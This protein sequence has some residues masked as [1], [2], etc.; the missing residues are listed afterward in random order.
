MTWLHPRLQRQLASAGAYTDVLNA[1]L[2][3]VSATYEDTDRVLHRVAQS[4]PTLMAGKSELGHSSGGQRSAE[5]EYRSLFENAVCGIYRDEL[6]GTPVRCN[7][8]LASL[9]GYDTEAEYISA[10]RGAH[11]AWYVE[12]GKSEHFKY[13]MLNEG[14]VRDMVSEVYRHKTREK[15]WITE[16]AWYVRDLEG[17]P[18]FIEGTIQD[19]TER[20]T[21]MA[22]VE[23]QANIDTLT[24]VASRFKF[25]NALRQETIANGEGC[26]LFSIDLD[27]FKEV[28][29]TLGHAAGDVVLKIT[30]ERLQMIADGAGLVARLGGDEFA[31]L[32]HGAFNT[33]DLEAF[34]GNII[35]VMR[36]P[37][38]VGGQN[39]I[40]GASVGIASFPT[41]ADD[42]EEL[43]ANADM[44]L[45]RA[46]MAGR[47]G[48]CIFD[49]ELRVTSQNNKE[50][51]SQLRAA[52]AEDEL[53]LHYQPIVLSCHYAY[54][55]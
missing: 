55:A 17:N 4:L 9:N 6:D 36:E 54:H 22:I 38:Q 27:R 43:L 23:R 41:H 13:L 48:F 5:A 1:L 37:V 3:E 19:A 51:E 52:I 53:E 39:L 10:V 40:V 7:P 8:A 31:L 42:A 45:Y 25:M 35:E 32:L 24:G 18:I 26:T 33:A 30:A 50:L 46:K 20:M 11:G 16:N 34:A 47:Y 2:P 29:D 14:R 44:A 28:N 15:F 21:T 12:P 49:I